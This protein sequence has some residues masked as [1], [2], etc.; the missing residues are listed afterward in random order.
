MSAQLGHNQG[1]WRHFSVRLSLCLRGFFPASERADFECVQSLF[2]IVYVWS[3]KTYSV[4]TKVGD[5]FFD[6]EVE[7]LLGCF[8]CPICSSERNNGEVV[9]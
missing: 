3:F 6:R 5:C 8:C 9:K 2:K 4:E 7:D 1:Q